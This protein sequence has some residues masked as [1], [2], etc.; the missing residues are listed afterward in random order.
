MGYW[1]TRGGSV[2]SHGRSVGSGPL[3][4]PNFSR[5]DDSS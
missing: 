5:L 2:N 1:N 4:R 3:L